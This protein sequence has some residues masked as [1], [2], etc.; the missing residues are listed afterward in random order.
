M[1]CLLKHL[2]RKIKT[3]LNRRFEASSIILKIKVVNANVKVA[4]KESFLSGQ[5]NKQDG[6]P[7][8]R[9]SNWGK[10]SICSNR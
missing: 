2:T 1:N 3:N 10:W 5:G 8:N 7:C 9:K 4:M 6:L